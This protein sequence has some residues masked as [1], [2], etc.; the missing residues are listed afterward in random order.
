MQ[1]ETSYDLSV[2]KNFDFAVANGILV[3][4]DVYFLNPIYIDLHADIVFT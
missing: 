4:E 1:G 3:S 2:E